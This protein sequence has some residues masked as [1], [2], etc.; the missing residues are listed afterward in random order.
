[1]LASFGDCLLGIQPTSWGQA[2]PVEV[3]SANP[4]AVSAIN[5]SALQINYRSTSPTR[6][7][8]IVFNARFGKRQR[9]VLLTVRHPLDP[10]KTATDQ[11]GDR[12]WLPALLHSRDMTVW[13]QTVLFSDGTDWKNAS[14]EH[15]AFRSGTTPIDAASTNESQ[16]TERNRSVIARAGQGAAG[17]GSAATAR[18]TAEQKIEMIQDKKASL[19]TVRSY[20]P[21]ATVAVDGNEI[22][23]TPTSFVL[24]RKD[25]PR[26]VHIILPGYQLFYRAILP[27]GST[28]PIVAT[29]TPMSS[30]K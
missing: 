24:I 27:D 2:G 6:I 12:S 11:F 10:G 4:R 3:M 18:L 13:P 20:P 21:G 23:T 14:I 26:D 19:C 30:N 1:M 28:I 16:D 7:S 8:G 29:L 22:G 15:C 25:S 17:E 9:P 5:G